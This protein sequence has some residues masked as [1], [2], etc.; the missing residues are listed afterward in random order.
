LQHIIDQED[1]G[2]R[3]VLEIALGDELAVALEIGEAQ[4]VTVEHAEEA[5]RAAAMLNIGL[6]LPVG[7]GEEKLLVCST[8]AASSGSI[9]V[10]QPPRCSI[11]A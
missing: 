8:K 9:A 5:R 10:R 3:I 2:F 11:P 4:R 1:E 7:G 6:A